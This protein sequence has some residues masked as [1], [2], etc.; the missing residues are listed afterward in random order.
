MIRRSSAGSGAGDAQ[1]VP[2]DLAHALSLGGP[3]VVAVDFM[4]RR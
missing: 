4:V 2:P 3:A 1:P